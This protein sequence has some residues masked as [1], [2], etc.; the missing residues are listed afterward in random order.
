MLT[1]V[2]CVD[3]DEVMSKRPELLKKNKLYA[4]V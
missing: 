1:N 2:V 3:D 4:C